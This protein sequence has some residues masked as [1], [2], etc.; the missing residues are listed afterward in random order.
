M[1]EEKEA[2]VL[3]PGDDGEAACEDY[4]AV[5]DDGGRDVRVLRD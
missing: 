1:L 2:G 5:V 4:D 3:G